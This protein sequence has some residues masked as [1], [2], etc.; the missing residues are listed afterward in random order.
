M[1]IVIVRKSC[2]GEKIL[3]IPKELADKIHA[4]YMNVVLDESGL[5]YTPI[6]GE[7]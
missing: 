1:K 2:R 7:A 5:K 6:P 3:V 4:T